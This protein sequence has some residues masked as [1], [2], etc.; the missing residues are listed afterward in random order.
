MNRRR[1]GMVVRIVGLV[2]CVTVF[3]KGVD[4]EAVRTALAQPG[5][6]RWIAAAGVLYLTG[7]TANG[8]GW[9]GIL[10]SL[11]YDVPFWRMFRHDLASVFWSTLLPG[12]GEVIKGFRLAGESGS[13]GTVAI[14]LVIA[15]LVGGGMSCLL[16]FAL[17]P[18]SS[19]EGPVRALAALVLAGAAGG[20]G[21]MLAVL[22]A[23]PEWL[24]RRVDAWAPTGR[25]GRRIRAIADAVVAR[26][27]AGTFPPVR[28][29]LLCGLCGV[30]THGAFALVHALCFGAV[31]HPLRLP[32]AAAIGTLSSLAQALPVSF[33]GVGV[34]ELIISQMGAL[35]GPPA[36]ANAA[37]I[38]MWMLASGV[39]AMGGISELLR[40]R[41]GP[42]KAAGGTAAARSI[43]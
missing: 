35:V 43:R 20:A 29:L 2:A 9:R 15:H 36:T 16:A 11:G 33:G 4:V 21:V 38:V 7:H 37:A 18:F 28:A 23:G 19:F 5:L 8:L 12:G 13:G 3:A 30:C 27:P 42:Q 10:R 40:L 25:I 14:A 26:V 39:V 34:R 17:L 32:D 22:R 41:G 24:R 1:L 31:G 6:G